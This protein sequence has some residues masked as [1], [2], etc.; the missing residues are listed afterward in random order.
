MPR[1]KYKEYPSVPYD[2]TKTFS[3][4]DYP[5]LCIFDIMS[6]TDSQIIEHYQS[7]NLVYTYCPNSVCC[8]YDN[9][10]ILISPLCQLKCQICHE[11]YPSRPKL[12]TGLQGNHK[13]LYCQLFSFC[14]G[15]NQEQTAALLG[16]DTTNNA[17]IRNFRKRIQSVIISGLKAEDI[18]LGG[19]VENPVITDE[20]QKGR[21]RKGNGKQRSH[22]T[23]VHG[24]VVGACDNNRFRF[25]MTSKSHPG[26]P[27]LEQIENTLVQWILPDS[28]LWTDGAK[29]Y[30]TFQDTYP[31]KVSYLV[32][33]NHSV[34]EW[35][36]RVTIEGKKVN[37]STNKIDGS[38]A[39]LRRFFSSHMVHQKDSFRYLKEFEFFYGAW[40]KSQNHMDRI[41]HYM[42]V[43]LD[44][45]NVIGPE[46]AVPWKDLSHSNISFSKHFTYPNF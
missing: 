35:V 13:L 42:N 5:S 18:K 33:L 39:H 20:M 17:K 36:R 31:E 4:E 34:G 44:L 41:L 10:L 43:K 29:C 12:F 2:R 22:P 45:K 25:T 23:V 1:S 27:R 37:A 28:T 3:L 8:R 7:H 19:G 6:K 40:T 26:P 38:W 24:D 16:F 15:H 11:T 14:L 21:R 32:Q 46:L 30:I 9:K